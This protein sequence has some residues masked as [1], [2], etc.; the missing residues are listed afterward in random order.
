MLDHVLSILHSTLGPL[1][2]FEPS[3]ITID[4]APRVDG[5][6][7]WPDII[8]IRTRHEEHAIALF[9]ALSNEAGFRVSVEIMDVTVH[10]YNKPSVRWLRGKLSSVDF[11]VEVHGPT[12]EIAKEL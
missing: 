4:T 8:A 6:R 1:E 12:S 7:Q 2:I 9:R 3:S 5:H 11:D 10:Y